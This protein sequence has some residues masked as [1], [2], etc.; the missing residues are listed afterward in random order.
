MIKDKHNPNPAYFILTE[1]DLLLEGDE[2]YDH[3]VDRWF[4]IENEHVGDLYKGVNGYDHFV[5]IRRK[6][7]DFKYEHKS[8]V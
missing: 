1:D 5:I 7:K 4:K 6:N 8:W 3:T 2:Y